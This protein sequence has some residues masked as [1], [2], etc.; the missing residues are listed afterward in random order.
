MNYG[1]LL[2]SDIFQFILGATQLRVVF[3]D[4]KRLEN[5]IT[6]LTPDSKV[7]LIILTDNEPTTEQTVRGRYENQA[8]I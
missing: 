7:T 1:Q 2:T 5:L 6:F 8:N 3:T 4:S